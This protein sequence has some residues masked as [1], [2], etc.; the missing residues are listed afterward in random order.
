MTPWYRIFGKSEVLPDPRPLAEF[1]N[2]FK[3]PVEGNFFGDDQGWT[4]L[5]LQFREGPFTVTIERF[6]AEEEGMGQTFRTW[7]A[8]IESANYDP[9][10]DWLMEHMINTLQ[11]FTIEPAAENA[12][13]PFVKNI[14]TEFAR[15]LARVTE[16]V[17][18][19]DD[20]GLF[21]AD[22]KLLVREE[23]FDESPG[24]V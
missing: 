3:T 2:Q 21:A 17:Y 13:E 23:I 18:Q 19:V 16:G 9:A 4:R 22:G 8:W 24:D 12:N 15:Y 11:L 1:A 7:A 14:C 20:Q 5:E 10:N 6:L